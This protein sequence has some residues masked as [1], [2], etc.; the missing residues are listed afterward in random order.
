ML[1][2]FD[3]SSEKGVLVVKLAFA[4]AILKIETLRMRR[5]FARVLAAA[6]SLQIIGH[7]TNCCKRP[8]AVQLITNNP[9]M[10]GIVPKRLDICYDFGTSINIHHSYLFL[11]TIS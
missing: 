3:F 6:K 2:K 7:V 9:L 5:R 4:T 11:S 1:I 10:K 8:I